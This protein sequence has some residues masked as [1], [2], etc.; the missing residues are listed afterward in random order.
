M[1]RVIVTS[2]SHGCAAA[3]RRAYEQALADGPVHTAVFLGDGISDFEPLVPWLELKD[4]RCIAVAGNN[5]WSSTE[6]QEKVFAVGRVLFYACHGHTRQ[7]EYSLDRLGYAACE[8]MAQV[9]LYGHTHRADIR[10]DGGLYL[11]NPGAVC[12]VIPGCV[13]YAQI[14]VEDDGRVLPKLVQWKPPVR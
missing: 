6:P 11:V 9:A 4:V 13:A 14:D 2:D 5:D 3:L 1:K 7:V 12:N 8:R 10:Q